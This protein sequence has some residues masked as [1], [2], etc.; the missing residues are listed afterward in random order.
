MRREANLAATDEGAPI[1]ETF[2]AGNQAL[3]QNLDV[4]K[5]KVSGRGK[6]AATAT[7]ESD[8]GRSVQDAALGAKQAKAK[9]ATNEAYETARNSPEAQMPVDPEPLRQFLQ[10]PINAKDSS[11]LMGLLRG[12]VPEEG[13]GITVGN[14]ERIRQ[15]LQAGTQSADGTAAHTAGEAV[16]VIDQMMEGAGGDL[17]AKARAAHRAERSEFKNQSAVAKLVGEKSGTTDRRVALENTT[18]AITS[19]SVEDIQNVKRS[20]LT[21]GDAETRTA[22]KAAWRDVRAQ[23]IQQIKDEATG[24]VATTAKDGLNL[25]PGA[26][27]RAI[28]RIGPERLDEIFGAGTHRQLMDVLDA[29]VTLKTM[30]ALGGPPVGSTTMQNVL[31][32]LSK[33]LDKIPVIGDTASGAVKAVQKLRDL[34][35]GAREAKAATTTPL[36]EAVAKAAGNAKK[37]DRLRKARGA[38]PV[39][40]LSQLP[41]QPNQ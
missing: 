20:L 9:A 29:S 36:S 13:G 26:L 6:T 37:T 22:G 5:G 7:N 14:L 28:D 32:F 31:S 16:K 25:Q 27:K 3:V 24:G 23:V 21:G 4:L 8:V 15:K 11:P 33:G 2:E 39:V 35:A 30:P 19:G 12:F 41:S 17:Y 34:G 40:P 10:D 1:A 18:K 38:L